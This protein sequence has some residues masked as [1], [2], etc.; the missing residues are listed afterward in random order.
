MTMSNPKL[1]KGPLG[2]VSTLPPLGF[3][4]ECVAINKNAMMA[5]AS[6]SVDQMPE[7]PPVAPAIMLIGGTGCCMNHLQVKQQSALLVPQ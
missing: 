5:A 3:C 6:Q 1:I 4:V 7:L 2:A